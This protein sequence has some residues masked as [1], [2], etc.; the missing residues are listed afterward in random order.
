MNIAPAKLVNVADDGEK[1]IQDHGKTLAQAPSS[2]S[3]N[4]NFG[5]PSQVS[6]GAVK[7]VD[8]KT[9]LGSYPGDSRR[10][11]SDVA[12]GAI[13]AVKAPPAPRQQMREAPL[14][15]KESPASPV[16]PTDDCVVG[17]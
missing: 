10:D 1:Q 6:V 11:V 17:D 8:R 14:S 15:G 13:A 3:I 9:V 5:V 7:P 4:S 16:M 2:D 12:D